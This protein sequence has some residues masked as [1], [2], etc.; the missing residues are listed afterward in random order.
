MAT[1][2]DFLSLLGLIGVPSLGVVIGWLAK[3]L[4]AQR[5]R[6]EALERGVQAMLRSQMINYYNKWFVDKGYA[7]IWVKDNFENVWTQYEALG[8]NGV[9]DKIHEE[10]MSLPTE[11][12]KKKENKK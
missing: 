12:S 7:P 11:L 4:K 3:N 5:K 10:F 9:M 8:E 2:R 1:I 6:Q